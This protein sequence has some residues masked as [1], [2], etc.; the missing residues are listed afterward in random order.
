MEFNLLIQNIDTKNEQTRGMQY[1]VLWAFEKLTQTKSQNVNLLG[2]NSWKTQ[3]KG[4]DGKPGIAN[5]TD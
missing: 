3:Y 2:E 4:E 1:V 5:K